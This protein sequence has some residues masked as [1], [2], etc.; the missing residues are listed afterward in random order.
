MNPCRREV[1]GVGVEQPYLLEYFN[2]SL[3]ADNLDFNGR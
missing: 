1:G 3:V 2:V